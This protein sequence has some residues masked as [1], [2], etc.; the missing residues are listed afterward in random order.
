MF[1]THDQEEAL[2]VADRVVVMSAGEIAQIGTPSWP[3]PRAEGPVEVFVR[4]HEL[5]VHA[6]RPD[7][8]ALAGTSRR[9]HAAGPR[10]RLEVLAPDAGLMQVEL[11]HGEVPPAGWA[12]GESVWLVPRRVQI[13]AAP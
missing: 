4:P 9:V 1:V 13:F 8:G 7:D 2:E 5:S 10:V 6:S 12:V 11:G 3:S